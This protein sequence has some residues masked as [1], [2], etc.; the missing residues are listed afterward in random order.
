M[1]QRNGAL[2]RKPR[3]QRDGGDDRGDGEH[4]AAADRL[5]HAPA[6][7]HHHEHEPE[8]ER[9]LDERQRRVGER[10][11]LQPP[12][13]QTAG[14]AQHP[15]RPS[16]QLPEQPE[17]ESAMLGHLARLHRLQGDSGRVQSGRGQ[18]QSKADDDL[19]HDRLAR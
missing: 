18:C 9:R 14:R 2:R 12:A 19:G 7:D 5:A 6:S 16:D 4:L 10:K 3:D 17:P 11:R 1:G 13:R 8:R 15:A